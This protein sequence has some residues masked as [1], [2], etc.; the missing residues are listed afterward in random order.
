MGLFLLRL[1]GL[2]LAAA[3]LLGAGCAARQPPPPRTPLLVASD[4]HTN[5]LARIDLGDYRLDPAAIPLPQ[6]PA[7][8]AATGD[9]VYVAML[10]RDYVEVV[11]ATS[12]EEVR[13]I[14]VGTPTL[15]LALAPGGDLLAATCPETGEVVL[16]DVASGVER[17]RWHLGGS[18]FGAAWSP[19]GAELYVS[20]SGKGTLA[21]LD[22]VS[23]EARQI[24]IGLG[25]R[26]LAADGQRLVVALFEENRLALLPRPLGSTPP[27][28]MEVGRGPAGLALDPGRRRVL[29]ACEASSQVT[30]VDLAEGSVTA[31]IPFPLGARPRELVVTPGG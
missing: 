11:S 21:V 27:R 2:A 17:R 31:R 26:G 9:T 1:A 20:N 3:G 25:P 7:G 8:L 29:V 28:R 22:P 6:G 19:T 24:P 16:L 13:R 4:L 23:G 15:R 5:A 30:V 18:P 12:G 10:G 14:P